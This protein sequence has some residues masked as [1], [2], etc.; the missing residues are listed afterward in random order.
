[1]SKNALWLDASDLSNCSVP[2]KELLYSNTYADDHLGRNKCI[3]QKSGHHCIIRENSVDFSPLPFS[4]LYI[5]MGEV[6]AA[7]NTTFIYFKDLGFVRPAMGSFINYVDKQGVG[8]YEIGK[9]MPKKL[10]ENCKFMAQ[11]TSNFA[12]HYYLIPRIWKILK[13]INIPQSLIWQWRVILFA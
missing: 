10:V 12:L 11:V 1:M 8:D 7:A 6:A 2:W 9:C 13:R 4:T 3:V 5:L